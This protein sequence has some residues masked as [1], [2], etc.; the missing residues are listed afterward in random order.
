MSCRTNC[1][2]TLLIVFALLAMAVLATPAFAVEPDDPCVQAAFGAHVTC[3]ANDVSIAFADNPRHTDGTPF[4]SA[5]G[6]IAGSKFDFIA[7]FHVTS[8][9]TSRSNI[10]LYF[11][12]SGSG[13]AVTGTTGTCENNVI[14]PPHLN[15]TGQVCLGSGVTPLNLTTS[16]CTGSGTY[17]EVDTNGE[18]SSGTTVGCGD[19]TTSDNNQVVTIEV[20]GADCVAGANG[21]LLLPNAVSWQQQGGVKFCTA[22]AP[23]YS[24]DDTQTAVPGAT[25]K[26]SHN[27]TFT[28]P[29]SVQSP[30]ASVAKTCTTA[31]TTTAGASCDAGNEG[32]TVTYHISVSNTSTFGTLTLNEICDTYYGTI[33][34]VSGQTAH[35]CWSSVVPTPPA[36]GTPNSSNNTCASQLGSGVVLGTAGSG[37]ETFSCS[38]QASQDETEPS[39]TDTAFAYGLGQD[40]KTGFSGH[41]GS[42][43]VTAEESP[44]TATITKG[45]DNRAESACFTI[46]YNVSVANTSGGEESVLLTGLTDTISGSAT[47]WDLTKINT[48]T[49]NLASPIVGTTCGVA[50]ARGTLAGSGLAGGSFSAISQGGSPYVCHFD[51][52]I[53]GTLGTVGSCTNGISSTDTVAGRATGDEA[54]TVSVTSGSKTVTECVNET[55]Q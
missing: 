39:I 11:Q 27:D 13:N 53:C 17:E 50:T 45:V 12:T 54:E 4:T 46:H 6:C 14:S 2:K 55:V 38:F 28:V 51:A 30:T 37:T 49:G 52:Q 32:G 10:G 47:A 18:P 5:N 16:T 8:T 41:S 3:T 15:K 20:D 23:N 7:D 40:G 21:M 36:P 25:S 29:I 22:S 44:S 19:I 31:I 42:V 33:A 48:D 43:T 9:A 34:L 1:C 26:C 24:W 35:P